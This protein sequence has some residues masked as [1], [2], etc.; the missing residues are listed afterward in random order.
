MVFST[1][2]SAFISCPGIPTAQALREASAHQE[3]G[4]SATGRE[5]RGGARRQQQRK[6]WQPV[7]PRG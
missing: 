7:G 1:L 2:S 5:H 3:E 6:D 4:G